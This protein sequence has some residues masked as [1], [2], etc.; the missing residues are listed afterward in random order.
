MES[1]EAFAVGPG[2]DLAHVD[3][4]K[5]AAR[6]A[7]V[8]GAEVGF[9]RPGG[10]SPGTEIISGTREEPSKKV[11]LNHR[12]RSPSMSPWSETEDDDGVVGHP[13]GFERARISPI[14]SSR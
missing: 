12:P 3:A 13:R 11:I 5:V 2:H 9:G 8:E 10:R 6:V 1:N 14:L 7:D 4:G